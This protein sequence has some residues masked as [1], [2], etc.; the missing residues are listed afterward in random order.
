MVRGRRIGCWLFLLCLAGLPQ[1]ERSRKV[2][3]DSNHNWTYQGHCVKAHT[4][5][6]TKDYD[7]NRLSNRHRKYRTER[8]GKR[9]RGSAGIEIVGQ[10][11]FKLNPGVVA[12]PKFSSANMRR[13]NDEKEKKMAEPVARRGGRVPACMGRCLKEL[14]NSMFFMCRRR[15]DGTTSPCII[16]H[17]FCLFKKKK[18]KNKGTGP[19]TEHPNTIYVPLRRISRFFQARLNLFKFKI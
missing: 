15:V 19:P 1:A 10:E 9:D 16:F 11:S 5:T 17:R 3:N 4:S 14:A 2:E 7:K 13:A 18:K 8:E 6:E 12:M